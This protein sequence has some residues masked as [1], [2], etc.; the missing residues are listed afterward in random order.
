MSILKERHYY[1]LPNI[2]YRHLD[3]SKDTDIFNKIYNT[4]VKY[5]KLLFKYQNIE[6]L[7]AANL[8]KQP[9][10]ISLEKET[11][12]YFHQVNNIEHLEDSNLFKIHYL[13]KSTLE[14]V[15]ILDTKR[16]HSYSYTYKAIKYNKSTRYKSS[17]C[18]ATW[19]FILKQDL[20]SDE[21]LSL[22]V[23]YTELLSNKV[24]LVE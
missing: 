4:N 18:Y 22:K 7:V 3:P 5:A 13:V 15:I 16:P 14:E 11:S 12:T 20:L 24:I 10:F 23:L 19:N 17:I 1:E 21:I 6:N 2:P 8:K 9:L